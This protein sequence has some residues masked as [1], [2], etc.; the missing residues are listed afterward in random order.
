VI[1]TG[2]YLFG[3]KGIKTK[4]LKKKLPFPN[5]RLRS[6]LLSQERRLAQF[7]IDQV[8][9]DSVNKGM[10]TNSYENYQPLMDAMKRIN[11]RVYDLIEFFDGTDFTSG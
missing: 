7:P 10:L 4:A 8:D 3:S 11:T 6:V 1:S 2:R 5:F 9:G